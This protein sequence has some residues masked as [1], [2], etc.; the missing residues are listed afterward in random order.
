MTGISEFIT[1]T[2]VLIAI[3][4]ALRVWSMLAMWT[5]RQ[6][7]TWM[8]VSLL[9]M[10]LHS[11][12][13]LQTLKSNDAIIS[14]LAY[15]SA[16]M[17]LTPLVTILGAR[18]PGIFAWHW[19][20]VL[21]MVVV[22]QWPAFSQLHGNHWRIPIE[23]SAPS[24]MGILVVLLMSAGTLLGTNSSCFALVYSSGIVMILTSATNM[25]VGRPRVALFGGIAIMAAMWTYQRNLRLQ[26]DRLQAASTVTQKTKSIV[27]LFSSL[28]GFAWTR[29]IQDRINQ[30]APRENW[31]VRLTPRGFE[32]PD[33]GEPTDDELQKPLESLIWVMGR[34]GNEAWLRHALTLPDSGSAQNS[35]NPQN[36]IV[37][38]K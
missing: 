32:R 2:P 27:D 20:V 3:C 24:T 23:L 7:W 26:F 31:T 28:Y 34:F 6:A 13:A 22:L 37:Q 10:L 35:D 25:A 11:I 17:L 15:L 29:R 14:A 9:A 30:F 21:P 8:L 36:P 19:F 18:R 33:G 4:L 12:L 38:P 5:A 16:T 1:I